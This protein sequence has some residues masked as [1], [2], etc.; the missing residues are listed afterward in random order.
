[1]TNREKV[2]SYE[3]FVRFLAAL[4]GP[5]CEVVLHCLDDYDHSILAIENGHISG[6]SVGD[7][8]KDYALDTIFEEKHLKNDFLVNYSGEPINGRMMRYSDF[9]IKDEKGK[10]I[11]FI[12]VNADVSLYSELKKMVDSQLSIMGAGSTIVPPSSPMM[13]ASDAVDQLLDVAIE[14]ANCKDPTHLTPT[15][16]VTILSTLNSYNLFEHKGSI[17]LVAEKLN[18]SEPTV[19]RILRN[20][21]SAR[22]RNK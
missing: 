7:G 2:L 20:I 11:G 6:R 3:P 19:Y 13:S 12:A 15:E 5:N 4:L 18:I 17:A 16:R 22:F 10:L 1:M 8:L 14:S 21:K 9:Y